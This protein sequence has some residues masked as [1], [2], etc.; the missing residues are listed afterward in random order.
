MSAGEPPAEDLTPAERGLARHLALLR[1][2]PVPGG[3]ALVARVVRTARWQEAVREPLMLI[4]NV[5][6]VLADAMQLVLGPVEHVD[7]TGDGGTPP[8]E[9]AP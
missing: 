9:N 1:E 3:A 7:G 6:G 5:A 2:A 4:G 8:A